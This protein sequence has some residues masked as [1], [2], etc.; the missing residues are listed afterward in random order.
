VE[1]PS[2]V[3]VR[4]CVMWIQLQSP[5]IG[6]A[7]LVRRRDLEIEGEGV[8]L[9]SRE[10]LLDSG[11]LRAFAREGARLGGD[12]RD[13]E[14]EYHLIGLRVPGGFAVRHDDAVALRRD[15]KGGQGPA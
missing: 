12:L 7:G 9:V 11:H 5:A 14:V 8:P 6:V 3:D 15:A 10:T 2:Q 4:P 1:Q 13:G